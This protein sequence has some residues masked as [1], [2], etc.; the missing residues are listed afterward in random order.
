MSRHLISALRTRLLLLGCLLVSAIATAQPTLQAS[1]QQMRLDL[2]GSSITASAQGWLATLRIAADNNDPSLPA[3][4][5]RWWHCRIGNLGSEP[6]RSFEVRL[7]DMGYTDIILP[8]WSL[9]SDGGAI[10]TRYERLPLSAIP[11]SLSSTSQR[12]F[13]TVPPGIT[14]VR[15]SK[16]FPYTW[17]DFAAYRDR[18]LDHPMLQE[19][20]LGRSRLDYPIV[21]WE[22]TNRAVPDDQKFRVWI[23]SGIHPSETTSYFCCEGLIDWLLSGDIAPSLLLNRIILNIVPMANPDGVVLGNYRTSASSTNLENEWL[24]PYNST[25]PEIIALRTRIEQFMGTPASPAPN[26]IVLLLNLHSTHGAVPPYHFRHTVASVD[27]DVHDLE[28]RWIDRFKARSP[29]VAR[30]TTA[31][32]SLSTRQYVESMMFDRWSSIPAWTAPP[33]PQRKVMA[34]T[35]EGVY[36]TGPEVGSW[37]TDDDYRD[38]GEA[39]GWAIADFFDLDLRQPGALLTY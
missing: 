2:T 35:F 17:D 28:N 18:V 19:H 15:L 11:T 8:V 36:G 34:I 31:S 16:Y 27:Q 38:V 33:N 3:S 5:R 1:G 23:H 30:G 39:M 22:I 26:P 14:D 13:I 32:S 9:S 25:Q 21:M 7:T 6:N 24:A 37:N 10:W 4:F 12:F 20:I 29:Y